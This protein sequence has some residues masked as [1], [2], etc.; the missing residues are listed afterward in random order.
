MMTR[1]FILS[2]RLYVGGYPGLQY[3]LTRL[4]G[5]VEEF[6]YKGS[7]YLGEGHCNMLRYGD[8]GPVSEYKVSSTPTEESVQFAAGYEFGKEQ[9]QRRFPTTKP[10]AFRRGW[11]SAWSERRPFQF[12]G[13]GSRKKRDQP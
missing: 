6:D 13:E 1:V 12:P 3:Q 11:Q 9:K 7:A 4:D 8:H 10:E 2:G 5:A